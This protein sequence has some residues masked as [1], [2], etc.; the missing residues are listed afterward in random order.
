MRS[1]NKS[2]KLYSNV[3]RSL[4]DAFTSVVF[5]RLGSKALR[6]LKMNF[7]ILCFWKQEHNVVSMH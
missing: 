3:L 4:K 7:S 2:E 1:V 5:G 6:P